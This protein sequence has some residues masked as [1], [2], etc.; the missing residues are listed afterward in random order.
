MINHVHL[1]QE[2]QRLEEEE[3]MQECFEA[4]I[5]D[6]LEEQINEWEKAKCVK[7]ALTICLHN[8]N[9]MIF[10]LCRTEEQNTALSALPKSQCNIEK[11]VLNPMADEFV[12]L[13]HQMD[14]IAS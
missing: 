11:S 2:L 6:E 12:P 4:M 13:C 10:Y 8:S 7:K 1:L 5:E 3:I 14:F 9:N